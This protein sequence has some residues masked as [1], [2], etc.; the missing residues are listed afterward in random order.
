MS[1]LPFFQHP[2][3]PSSVSN[4]L[5]K[6]VFPSYELEGLGAV[7]AYLGLQSG[8]SLGGLGKASLISVLGEAR[9]K[10]TEQNGFHGE[11]RLGRQRTSKTMK[12]LGFPAWLSSL[13]VLEQ[14]WSAERASWRGPCSPVVPGHSSSFQQLHLSH[15]LCPALS[16]WSLLSVIG[17]PIRDICFWPLWRD[18]SLLPQRTAPSILRGS[19]REA[20]MGQVLPGHIRAL[21]Q[22]SLL[23]TFSLISCTLSIFRFLASPTQW[24]TPEPRVGF[25]TWSRIPDNFLCLCC[26]RCAPQVSH[27]FPGK[28]KTEL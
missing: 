6:V 11:N 3:V 23:A 18:D 14:P 2:E 1:G 9:S 7:Q 22:C 17:Q 16:V 27:N 26:P 13:L 20:S 8:S 15:S 4:A 10:R 21:T 24:P 28:K 12:H 25:N 19:P 5:H